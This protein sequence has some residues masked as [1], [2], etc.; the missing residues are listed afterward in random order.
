[1]VGLQALRL[2]IHF[3]ESWEDIP[4]K[5]TI[6]CGRVTLSRLYTISEEQRQEHYMAIQ[7]MATLSKQRR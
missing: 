4:T 5:M 1:M 6:S 7:N 2:D 3:F